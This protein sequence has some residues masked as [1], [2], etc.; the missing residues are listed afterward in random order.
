MRVADWSGDLAP[1]TTT[2]R[3]LPC[4][5]LTQ[6]PRACSTAP[7]SWSSAYVLLFTSKVEQQNS[8]QQLYRH[9]I[10]CGVQLTLNVP[11]FIRASVV[12]KVS[13][14]IYVDYRMNGNH[15]N[16]FYY[17]LVLVL[18]THLQKISIKVVE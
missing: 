3:L 10:S 4:R 9:R 1:A 11:L 15:S 17:E 16:R 8:C 12:Q 2:S 7:H 18:T 13:S 14:T 5:Q 6:F